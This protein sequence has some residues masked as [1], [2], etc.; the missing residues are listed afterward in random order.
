MIAHPDDEDYNTAFV[1]LLAISLIATL[2]LNVVASPISKLFN[3]GEFRPVLHYTSFMIL[4]FGGSYAH[5]GW[6]KRNFKFRQLA[7]RNIIGVSLGGAVGITVALLGYGLTALVLN[8][9]VAGFVSLGLL[10][11][12]IP[13][14]PRLRYS[15]ERAAHILSTS[16]PLGLSH[17]LQFA[18]QNFDTALV[19]YII[20]PFAGGTYAAAK[21]ITLATFLAVWAPI[22]NVA[23]SALA[24]G[25][26]R[27]RAIQ[28]ANCYDV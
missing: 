2:L 1:I 16:L 9:L 10:W 13:W 25:I 19:T 6:A 8:Q 20:G 21:R 7:I 14:Q 11:V 3:I 24:G 4:V 28:T 27:Y 22:G 5:V 23:Q 15:P 17:G 26:E 18:V 12:S